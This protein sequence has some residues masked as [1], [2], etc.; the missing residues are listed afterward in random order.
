MKDDCVRQP[1]VI[2]AARCRAL[3]HRPVDQRACL[4]PVA[5]RPVSRRRIV[6]NAVVRNRF[7]RRGH[8]IVRGV[9]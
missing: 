6:S 7:L 1:L 9:V 5:R 3:G 2:D 4:E 8:G